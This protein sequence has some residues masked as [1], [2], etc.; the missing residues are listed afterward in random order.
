MRQTAK[1]CNHSGALKVDKYKVDIFRAEIDSIDN[2]LIALFMRRMD[3]S[4]AVAEYKK[5]NNIPILNA[6]REDEI[7]NSVAQKGGEYGEYAR[8]LY[9]K[10]MELSRDLQEKM[11]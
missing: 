5:A 10:I 2:E 1:R 11:M 6:G 9:K 4:R 3:C 8:E 7:L